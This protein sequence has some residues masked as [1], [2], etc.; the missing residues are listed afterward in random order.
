MSAVRAQWDYELP[1]RSAVVTCGRL[2]KLLMEVLQTGVLQLHWVR[3][4]SP[5]STSSREAGLEVSV[6]LC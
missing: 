6:W 1:I 4:F 2:G 3:G 5:N